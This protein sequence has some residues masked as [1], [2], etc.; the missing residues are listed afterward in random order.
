M[1]RV[2]NC[3]PNWHP[4]LAHVLVFPQNGWNSFMSFIEV[5]ELER[6]YNIARE[7]N[8]RKQPT[9]IQHIDPLL[10]SLATYKQSPH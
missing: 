5:S 6:I 7:Y 10:Y 3:T 9:L 4:K 1:K 8:I 2:L